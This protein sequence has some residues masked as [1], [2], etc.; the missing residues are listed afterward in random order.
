MSE[1]SDLHTYKCEPGV[2]KI[3]EAAEW[4]KSQGYP[5]L[6]CIVETFVFIDGQQHLMTHHQTEAYLAL[7][8][9]NLVVD[10]FGNEM[11]YLQDL[12]DVP[13][14]TTEECYWTFNSPLDHQSLSQ[15]LLD[16]SGDICYLIATLKP[17]AQFDREPNNQYSPS[18]Y[19]DDE[20]TVVDLSDDKLC[21]AYQINK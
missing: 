13:I 15:L 19:D 11:R 2:G 21:H 18:L 5:A 4:L 16:Y 6:D 10:S 1:N 14:E 17:L 3:L 9:G 7:L 20:E 12:F 8:S